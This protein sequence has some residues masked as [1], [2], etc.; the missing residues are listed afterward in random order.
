MEIFAQEFE[1]ASCT[2]NL[3]ILT[4]TNIKIIKLIFDI[5]NQILVIF[6]NSWSSEFFR[7]MTESGFCKEDCSL[8]NTGSADSQWL[9]KLKNS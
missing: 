4:E 8:Q 6:L 2:P 3:I 9:K 5:E 7:K 1:P